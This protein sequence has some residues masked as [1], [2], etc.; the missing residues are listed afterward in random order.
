MNGRHLSLNGY[1]RKTTPYLEELERS[2]VLKNFGVAASNFTSS[3][4]SY[5]AFIV[6]A[7]DEM[8]ASLSTQER[9]ALPNIFQYAKSMNYKTWYLDGQMKAYWGGIED[10]KRYIDEAFTLADLDPARIEDYQKN[11]GKTL[12]DENERQGLKQWD[13][14]LVLAEKIRRIFENSTGNFVFVYKRGIHFPYEKN[15]PEENAVWQPVYKF[16]SQWETPPAEASNAITNSYDN[17]LLYGTDP[18]F[19]K[20]GLERPLPNGTVIVYTSDHGEN[21]ASNGRAGHGGDTIDEA[22]VPLFIIGIEKEQGGRI[23]RAHHS[24]IFPTLLDLMNFPIEPRSARYEPSLFDPAMDT[25]RH[26]YFHSPDGRRFSFE[27]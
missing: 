15:Y 21:L 24:N 20:L 9:N 5:D 19:K 23:S 10:D 7:S 1:E 8:L 14:D 18:F 22:S 3:Q 6:G 2:G 13:I 26:R 27:D 17:A 12:T 11:N 16:T 25:I 4:P